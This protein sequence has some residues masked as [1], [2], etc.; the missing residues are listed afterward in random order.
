[1]STNRDS[2]WPF[3]IVS[4]D[5]AG[6]FGQV[7]NAV[8]GL[9]DSTISLLG[10]LQAVNPYEGSTFAITWEPPADI[11]SL[12]LDLPNPPSL[13]EATFNFP[14]P[15]SAIQFA[16]VNIPEIELPPSPPNVNL[17]TS[18]QIN[19]PEAP[20][21]PDIQSISIPEA[22]NI[23]IP[24]PP[25]FLNVQI[26]PFSSTGLRGDY[27]DHLGQVDS[28]QIEFFEPEP[29]SYTR[30]P[31]Y[32]SA[33][34][35]DLKNLVRGR[36]RGGTGLP[37]E[38][39]NLIWGRARD[40][41][42]KTFVADEFSVL[43]Q[44]DSLGFSHPPGTVAA[45]LNRARQDYH[46]KL[47]SLSRDISIKQAELEIDNLRNSI[48]AGIKLEQLLISHFNE[49]QKLTF[50]AAKTAVNTSVEVYN[51]RVRAFQ[52]LLQKYQ[53][54]VD[55]HRTL[56]EEER[57]KI[58]AYKSEIEGEKAKAEVNHALANQYKS[59]I[60]AS[61]ALVEIF[62]AQVL[63]AEAKI[64][65]EKERLAAA[66][67]M[68][69]AYTA[70]IN[71]EAAKVQIFDAQVRAEESKS[72]I[73]ESQVKAYSAKAEV[74]LDKAKLMLSKV[75]TEAAV[76]QAEW[77]GYKAQVQAG[78]AIIDAAF[79]RNSNALEAYK[80]ASQAAVAKAETATKRFE[81]QIQEYA[82]IQNYLIQAAKIN[83]DTKNSARMAYTE[84][85]KVA[86]QTRAQM[87]ASAF[88]TINAAISNNVSSVSQQSFNK[89]RSQ[90]TNFNISG[91]LEGTVTLPS[92]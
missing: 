11:R 23:V 58:E 77:D 53:V 44:A 39:E 4:N 3:P 27:L 6:Q 24:S 8:N 20:S 91:E 35:E 51:A 22:P 25:A 83:L 30:P 47:S 29:F 67:E 15:P 69:R 52:T 42:T 76:K 63:A 5:P 21:I 16:G 37:P 13:A 85:A 7:W 49:A 75:Q 54:F 89:S 48:E 64:S 34:L 57:F 90:S 55:A 50:E 82:T 38:I 28:T 17:P 33:L 56:I 59:Q 40:R 73:Y 92:E 31:E 87:A 12:N 26:R 79:K 41:E 45:L 70:K 46:N 65:V 88:G 43:S 60:E 9:W 61:L 14:S 18:P 74:L 84:A 32:A 36:L 81:A 72:K 71:A 1:M 86:A 80:I 10:R 19:I 78:A 2:N 66:G 68:I 62:K